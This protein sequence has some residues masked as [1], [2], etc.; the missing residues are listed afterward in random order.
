VWLANTLMDLPE[1][2]KLYLLIRRQKSSPAQKRFEKMIEGSP[3]F[4]PVFEKYGERLG[5]LLADKVEV[6]EGDV[7]Q[8]GLGLDL[9]GA[10]RLR[11]DLDLII[12]SSGL[13]DFNPDLRDALAVNVDSTHH[14]IEF[15]RGSDHAALLHLSTCYVAG[16]R[17]GRVSERVLSKLHAAGVPISTPKKSGIASTNWWNR[18]RRKRRVLKSPR[19]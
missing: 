12:N 2:G 3:V 6:V 17:D 14:L 10:A 15:I 13:T 1:I 8:P 16:Q 9:R 19:N 7:S 5:R 11:G 18:R 4:D